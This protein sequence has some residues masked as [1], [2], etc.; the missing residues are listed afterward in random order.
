M[1]VFS[2]IHQY[3]KHKPVQSFLIIVV[4][5]LLGYYV[6][7]KFFKKE[8]MDMAGKGAAA[9]SSYSLMLLLCL[10]I[11]YLILYYIVKYASKNAIKETSQSKSK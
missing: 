6:Y 10:I 2:Q 5:I 3:M 4:L 1:S 11:P 9:I 8:H 7:T